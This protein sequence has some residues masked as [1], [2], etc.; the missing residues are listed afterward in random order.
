MHPIF[1]ILLTVQILICI[2]MGALILIQ[3][4]EG[5]ALGMGGGPSGFM[6]ARGAGNLLTRLT[7]ILAVL[8]FVNSIGMTIVGNRLNKATSAVDAVDT[9][10]LKATPLTAP[11][12]GAAPK[13]AA[14]SSAAPSL[15]DLPLANAPVAAPV[16]SQTA[17]KPASSGKAAAA[18]RPLTMPAPLVMPSASG[19]STSPARDVTKAKS[20]LGDAP[21]SQSASSTASKPASST[22]Q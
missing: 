9:S 6:S 14:S 19:V 16:Q 15:N 12:T 3:R 20:S 1:G 13:E 4:S 2:A 10:T 17:V 21:V 11:S 7:G 5:G 8:F 18:D 22:P